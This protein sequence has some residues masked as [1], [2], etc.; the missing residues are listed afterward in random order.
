MIKKLKRKLITL[1]MI[2]LFLL[3][4]LMVCGMNF[5]NY[6]TIT[7]DADMILDFLSKHEGHF[8]VFTDKPNI[9]LPPHASPE[10]PYESRYFS[11]LLRQDGTVL[12]TETRRIAAVD[13]ASASALGEEALQSGRDRGFLKQFRFLC[14]PVGSDCFR[15]T[16]LNCQRQMD[17]FRRFLLISS[18]SALV[19]L[20][21]VFFVLSFFADRMIRPIAESYE[22]QKRFI[23]DAGHEIKTPLAIISA[24]TDLLDIELGANESLA[25]IRRQTQRLSALTDD[26]VLLTR[27][28]ESADA[29]SMLP[30]PASDII[31]D[32]AMPFQTL[33]ASQEKNLT[34]QIAPMLSMTGD[35]SRIAQLVSILLDN[36]LKYS[37]ARS[38]I[39]LRFEK[40]NRSLSLTVEN[41]TNSELSDSDLA[42][43]FDRFYRADPSRNSSTGG[44]G[45]GLSVASAI[46]TAHGGTV[47]A[48]MV[49]DHHDA[50]R[51]NRFRITALF[52]A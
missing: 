4:T 15:V 36:A 42:H 38:E 2:S 10:L 43:I 26:L 51:C 27:M 34:L 1:S 19:G 48:A 22:K 21:I 41:S 44:H 47:R 25:D 35:S 31:S 12:R 49:P 28:E 13:S 40:Q 16:F 9:P 11:V 32:A 23:T 5:I 30:F 3:L 14:S 37:P 46:V 29:F 7:H 45:I 52:P 50:A 6:H 20:F 33:A 18:S 8:P 39:L 24:N 17:S